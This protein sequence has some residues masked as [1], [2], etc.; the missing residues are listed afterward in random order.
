[1][2]RANASGRQSLRGVFLMDRKG[3]ATL[4]PFTIWVPL[5]RTARVTRYK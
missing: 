3:V 5:H 4:R 1:M 2:I